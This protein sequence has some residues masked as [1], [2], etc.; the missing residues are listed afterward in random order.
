LDASRRAQSEPARNMTTAGARTRSWCVPGAVSR[1]DDTS[2][3]AT[4]CEELGE[5]AAAVS[6]YASALYQLVVVTG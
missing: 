6:Y 2:A 4:S 5:G 3:R 1:G